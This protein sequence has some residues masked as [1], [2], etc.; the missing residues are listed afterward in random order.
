VLFCVARCVVDGS[1]VIP[2]KVPYIEQD[3]VP[4][5]TAGDIILHVGDP[6]DRNQI[7][8]VDECNQ[9]LERVM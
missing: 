7:I 6:V 5:L 2:N 9:W 4:G 3:G 1:V 8:I